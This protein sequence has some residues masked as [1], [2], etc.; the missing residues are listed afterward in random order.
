[1][2]P[3]NVM[4][5][6]DADGIPFDL[7][8]GTFRETVTVLTLLWE[9]FA[10]RI[11][12]IDTT[13]SFDNF[14]NTFLHWDE[15]TSTSPSGRLLGLYK[16]LVTANCDR[17]SEFQECEDD[18]QSTKANKQPRLGCH[19]GSE[20]QSTKANTTE[21]LDTIYCIATS[22]GAAHGLYLKWPS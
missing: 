15:K 4:D 3:P 5:C 19:I 7:P 12:S 16:S 6:F 10:N 9:A 1:M 11:P 2:T 8:D 18:N 17:G 20:F 21:V 13:I 22:A 14:I